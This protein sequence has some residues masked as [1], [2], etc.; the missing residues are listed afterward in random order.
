MKRFTD[1]EKWRDPWFRRLSPEHKLAWDYICTNCDNS[2]VWVVDWDLFNFLVGVKVDP[3]EVREAFGDRVRD[4]GKGRWWIPKFIP[5]QFG[6]LVDVSRV[7]QS[8]L[9]LLSRHGIDSLEIGYLKGIQQGIYTPKDKDIDKDKDKDQDRDLEK[10][11]GE[12]PKPKPSGVPSS[13]QEAVTWADMEAVPADFAR[14]IFHQCEGVGWLD[15]SQRPITSWRGYIKSRW[16]R[17]QVTPRVNGANGH[18]KPDHRTERRAREFPQEIKA[19][20]L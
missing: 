7:H 5:F 15:G 6:V 10:G 2:G 1:T 11:S 14:M 4:I 17:Q 8:V 3:D 9:A 18:A 13:E 12:K 20:R 16:S 19:K